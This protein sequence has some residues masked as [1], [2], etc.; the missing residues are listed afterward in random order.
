MPEWQ[1]MKVAGSLR[2]SGVETSQGAVA[3]RVRICSA[4]GSN[5]QFVSLCTGVEAKDV[6]VAK[7]ILSAI[8]SG[9]VEGL[10][11]GDDADMA[12]AEA[13]TQEAP[14]NGGRYEIWT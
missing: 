13:E 8:M 2:E 3:C 6:E 1:A 11:E 10:P 4:P 9:H 12:E 5:F 7:D 14:R